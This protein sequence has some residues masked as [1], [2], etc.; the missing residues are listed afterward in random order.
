MEIVFG[1][2]SVARALNTSTL[3]M[4]VMASSSAKNE[5]ALA[6]RRAFQLDTLTFSTSPKL[7]KVGG[8][9]RPFRTTSKSE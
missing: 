8:S 1:C 7:D 5:I 2:F 6:G 3:F 4:V 9:R